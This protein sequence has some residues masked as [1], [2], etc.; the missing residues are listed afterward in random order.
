MQWLPSW[1]IPYLASRHTGGEFILFL[2]GY[3]SESELNKAL[4]LL[5]YIQQ[6]PIEQ[7]YGDISIPVIFSF[8][9][10]RSNSSEYTN[11]KQLLKDAIDKKYEI[12][13]VHN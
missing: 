8:G 3:N 13:S 9:Y 5:T 4:N 1:P 7:K 2:Y 6:H 11:Y 10:S 12:L